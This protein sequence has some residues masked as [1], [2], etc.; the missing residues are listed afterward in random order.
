MKKIQK[1]TTFKYADAAETLFVKDD[2]M[3]SFPVGQVGQF[4]KLW[5]WKTK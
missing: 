4:T 1:S 2:A 3:P 5:P